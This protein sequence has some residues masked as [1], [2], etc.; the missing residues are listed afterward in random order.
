MCRSVTLPSDSNSRS[1]RGSRAR[2]SAA[3]LDA[4]SPPAIA[5][6]VKKS[7]RVTS[8]ATLARACRVPAGSNRSFPVTI[9][10]AAVADKQGGSSHANHES[11]PYDTERPGTCHRAGRAVRRRRQL[12]LQRPLVTDAGD[13]DRLPLIERRQVELELGVFHRVGREHIDA[14]WRHAPLHA[15]AHVPDVTLARSPGRKVTGEPPLDVGE[16]T[17]AEK[18]VGAAS[19]LHGVAVSAGVVSL[20]HALVEARLAP[21]ERGAVLGPR[22]I[23]AHRHL[24]RGHLDAHRQVEIVGALLEED[25]ARRLGCVH[26]QEVLDAQDAAVLRDEL[27]V[28]SRHALH[29]LERTARVA[30]G[31]GFSGRA[32]LRPE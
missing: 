18:L 27:R 31:A 21:F 6:S 7:R 23:Q 25:C 16:K 26:G 2:A 3:G 8:M 4:W 19:V 11:W 30:V 1:A 17:A 14:E 5:I 29:R 15:L 20:T 13:A 32:L 9:G 10:A 22:Q 24:V 28:A 12:D